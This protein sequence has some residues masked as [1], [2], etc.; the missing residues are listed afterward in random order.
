MKSSTITLYS[1]A[2]CPFCTAAEALLKKRGLTDITKIRVDASA[3][4]LQDMLAHTGRKT[5]PQIFLGDE[6]IGGF[7]DLV[8]YD[9]AGRLTP[10]DIKINH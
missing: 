6:Y 5:V 3:E 7:D 1:T 4:N 8:K 10:A 2:A 9:S